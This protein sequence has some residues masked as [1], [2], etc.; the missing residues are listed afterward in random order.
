MW[1]CGLVRIW[2]LPPKQ[3]VKGSNPFTPARHFSE[4]AIEEERRF[5]FE[6]MDD[7][8]RKLL[9][10]MMWEDP[11]K[12]LREISMRLGI[13][14]QATRNRLQAL[15]EKGVFKNLRAVVSFDYR[16]GFLVAIWGRSESLSVDSCLER[17]GSSKLTYRAVVLGGGSLYVLGGLTRISDLDSYVRFVKNAAE[18]PEPTVGIMCFDDGVCPIIGEDTRGS[19]SKLSPIDIKIMAML[20]DDAR[21]PVAEIADAIGVSAGTVRKH[22]T[23]MFSEGS[24]LF[25]WPYDLT[26]GEAMLTLLFVKLRGRT[27]KVRVAKRLRSKDPIHL[28]YF[29]SFSNIPDLLVG[30]ISS[31]HMREI[32]KLL[33]RIAEDEDVLTVTPNLIYDERMYWA[34]DMRATEAVIRR[35]KKGGKRM[36]PDT[37]AS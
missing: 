10:L 8:D 18:M 35:S 13:S 25:D 3:V 37:M 31:E 7:I 12:P 21:K 5:R 22:L 1:A 33:R 23:G 24:M 32:R 20:Q 4:K 34:K 36:R 6:E 11:R 15:A 17:L 26:S 9:Y 30:I 2:H 27:D 29:V 16:G 28:I 14:R 19:F